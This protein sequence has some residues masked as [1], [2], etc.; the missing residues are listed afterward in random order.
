[1]K[2]VL[3]VDDEPTVRALICAGLE[4]VDL[5]V[6]AVA[7]GDAALNYVKAATPDLIL[8]DLALPGMNGFEIMDCVRAMP[9]AASV[10]ILLLTGLE[11]LQDTNANG[12]IQKPFNLDTL[13]SR[14]EFWLR[15]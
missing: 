5:Q 4:R 13:R 8:L 3:A 9:A 15:N 12:V 14:V 2:R 11:P 7:D 10:P 1:M 6:T